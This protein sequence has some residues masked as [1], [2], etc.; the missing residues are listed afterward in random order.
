M[1]HIIGT[2]TIY[3]SGQWVCVSIWVLLKLCR[4]TY[5]LLGAA[6]VLAS[7]WT[8]PRQA[9]DLT[10]AMFSS[11]RPWHILTEPVLFLSCDR[12]RVLSLYFNG[13][14]NVWWFILFLACHQ[15]DPGIQWKGHRIRRALKKSGFEV[16]F[17]K[18]Y[19]SH[20]VSYTVKHY[21]AYNKTIQ[22]LIWKVGGGWGAC[23]GTQ[24]FVGGGSNM[25]GM[26]Y[27]GLGV[28]IET[29]VEQSKKD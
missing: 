6:L 17:R 24:G 22:T 21:M 14:G 23:G 11:T 18:L 3:L 19:D 28:C 16:Q 7:G 29:D 13:Q 15:N 20:S 25:M 8:R 1:Y 4:V 27:P 9:L 26:G 2:H 5:S 12:L 10:W